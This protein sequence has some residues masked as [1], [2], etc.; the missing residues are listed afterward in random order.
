[1]CVVILVVVVVVVTEAG[2]CRTPIGRIHGASPILTSFR[3]PSS[4]GMDEWSKFEW[5]FN[6][7]IS[8]TCFPSSDGMDEL[9]RLEYN[10]NQELMVCR[11]FGDGGVPN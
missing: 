9:K 8:W 10:S 11:N 1:M 4:D 5:K 3:F 2:T 6:P 7:R